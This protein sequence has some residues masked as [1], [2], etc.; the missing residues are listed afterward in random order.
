MQI[1]NNNLFHFS[2]LN[3]TAQKVAFNGEWDKLLERENK[4]HPE[5]KKKA[6][7]FDERLEPSKEELLERFTSEELEEL[8]GKLLIGSRGGGFV[9]DDFFSIPDIKCA[10]A[11]QIENPKLFK[12]WLGIPQEVDFYFEEVEYNHTVI[13]FKN[14]DGIDKQILSKASAKWFW[15]LRKCAEILKDR[16]LTLSF[17]WRE[18]GN[19]LEANQT[20]L[21]FEDGTEYIQ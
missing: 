15:H 8:N 16:V 4:N 10:Q 20:T 1:N 7:D 12:K 18:I 9:Y 14:V 2:Q 11:V 5:R 3:D 19:N 17:D 13:K 6:L 21:Y